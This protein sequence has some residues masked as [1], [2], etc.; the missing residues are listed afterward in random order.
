MEMKWKRS[1]AFT[2]TIF[3]NDP[4]VDFFSNWLRV[5]LFQFMEEVNGNLTGTLDDPWTSEFEWN[6][7]GSREFK[8]NGTKFGFLYLFSLYYRL[9]HLV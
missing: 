7:Q 9:N 1:I 3:P 4:I 6:H 8:N 2:N 5:F